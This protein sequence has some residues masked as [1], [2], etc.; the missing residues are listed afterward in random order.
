MSACGL[1]A[2]LHGPETSLRL[3]SFPFAAVMAVAAQVCIRQVG[4]LRDCSTAVG[5]RG[6]R[7][8]GVRLLMC[9]T[10]AWSLQS[11]AV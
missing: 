8:G 10:T 11:R 9:T 6:A 7:P 5:C 2:V 1:G 3:T 4:A